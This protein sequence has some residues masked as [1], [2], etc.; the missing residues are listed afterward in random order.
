MIQSERAS[1]PSSIAPVSCSATVSDG[2]SR[3]PE[4]SAESHHTL[5]HPAPQNRVSMH[6]PRK[7][8]SFISH[9]ATPYARSHVAAITLVG[10]GGC[11]A[12]Q[13]TLKRVIR[14]H[15]PAVHRAGPLPHLVGYRCR[16]RALLAI[17]IRA[18]HVDNAVHGGVVPRKRTISHLEYP[19]RWWDARR[20]PVEH[21]T[22]RRGD[23]Y[24]QPHPVD[25]QVRAIAPL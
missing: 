14:E 11:A 8:A 18:T 9:V 21:C 23:V 16:V 13:H 1:H 6:T 7:S 5:E 10:D 15:Y 12:V 25:R 3:S 19:S 22:V 4:G 20:E 17:P 24:L 2:C